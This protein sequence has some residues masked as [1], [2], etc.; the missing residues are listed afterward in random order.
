MTNGSLGIHV[1]SN[2]NKTGDHHQQQQPSPTASRTPP[3]FG[4][5]AQM[6]CNNNDPFCQSKGRER[7]SGSENGASLSFSI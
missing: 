5:A 7:E 1:K 4:E 3:D 6:F 2:N